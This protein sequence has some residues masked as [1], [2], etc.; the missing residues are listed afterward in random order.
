MNAARTIF[1]FTFLLLSFRS[2]GQLKDTLSEF[3]LKG[4]KDVTSEDRLKSFSSGQKIVVLDSATLDKYRMQSLAAV[5]NSKTP[6]FVK[7]YGLNGLAT[8]N[9]R[10]SSAAQSQVYWNGIPISNASLGI[11]DIST[12]PVSLLN[13][14]EVVYGGSSSLWGSGNVGGAIVMHSKE[15]SFSN[16]INYSAGIG[17]GS[18]SQCIAGGSVSVANSRLYS[19]TDL[20]VQY[21]VNNFPYKDQ[22]GNKK[23]L[24][25]SQLK[26]FGFQ[27]QL[28]IKI[29]D[30]EKLKLIGWV[31]RYDREIPPA[32]FESTSLKTRDETSVRIMAEYSRTKLNTKAYLRS[33]FIKENNYYNDAA[34]G[35]ESQNSSYQYFAE[36]GIKRTM[37][38]HE[39]LVF[40][41]VHISTLADQGKQ[42]NKI[43]GVAAYSFTNSSKRLIAAASAR[44]EMIDEQVAFTSGINASYRLLPSLQF[45]GSVQK[46][47]RAPTL[48]ELYYQPGG[49]ADLKSE[50]GWSEELGY[51]YELHSD[52]LVI[53][54]DLSFFHRLID[55]WIL[56]LGGAI[57]TPHNIASVQSMGVETENSVLLKKGKY[58]FHLGLNTTYISAKTASS[59]LPGDGSIGMQIPY[60]PKINGQLSGGIDIKNLS[61]DYILSFTGSR[62]VN[63]DETDRIPA[64]TTSNI[65]VDYL[66]KRKNNSINLSLQLNNLFSETYEV[67]KARPMPGVNWLF[68]LRIQK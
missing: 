30:Y 58:L 52:E 38:N 27:Q 37:G 4:K 46:S 67:V 56:W 32:L 8:L 10:G 29:N 17:L 53:K 48:N 65:L 62:F 39:L 18:F 13:R 6:V 26:G 50:E 33:A 54:H 16:A 2:N 7:S 61:V 59:Y 68:G 44:T 60:T 31:Q 34:I 35:M 41:P 49:N 25:N 28:A 42:Q 19:S 1:T 15:P 40:L 22:S 51:N 21:G 36:A 20:I 12:L 43:A 11:T 57:W 9:F 23:K 55:N 3:R 47:Y 14:V 63:V 45:R 5:L 64:Y 24:S 66:V